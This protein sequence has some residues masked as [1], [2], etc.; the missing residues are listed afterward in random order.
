M[1][2][3]CCPT[4]KPSSEHDSGD[5]ASKNITEDRAMAK[6]YRDKWIRGEM[7]VGEA[8]QLVNKKERGGGQERVFSEAS[9]SKLRNKST[10]KRLKSGDA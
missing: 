4:S 8:E 2:N 9:G 10:D 1:G 6:L 7:K 3:L 5:R